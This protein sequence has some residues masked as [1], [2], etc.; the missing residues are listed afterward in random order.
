MSERL[1]TDPEN[2][3]TCRACGRDNPAAHKFCGTCGAD[4]R[5][6]E[7][8]P[9]PDRQDSTFPRA[10]QDSERKESFSQS[11]RPPQAFEHSITNPQEL[12]L[13]RSFRP[14]ESEDDD[15]ESEDGPN[16]RLYIGVFLVIVLIGLGF[17][18]WRGVQRQ[19][20]GQKAIAP[21]AAK[22]EPAQQPTPRTNDAA[23]QSQAKPSESQPAPPPVKAEA[24]PRKPEVKT[25]QGRETARKNPPEPSTAPASP[26]N[27]SE[28]LAMAE[29]YLSSGSGQRRDSAEAA[30]WLWKSIA[31]HNA[32]ATV[33]LADLYLR[34]DGVSKNCDQ[35][36][37]LLDSAA[38]K[39]SSLA[40]ERLR[41]L[42]AFGC[43]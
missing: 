28:E 14:A 26:G 4:L 1:G 43:Q 9:D 17:M 15:W 30:K 2:T 19:N 11:V 38:R 8:R 25:D 31:K 41:N 18:V 36:R 34:G 21:Q 32:E 12:S 10:S 7:S 40:G 3:V 24:P 5:V 29:R 13:F 6:E 39:G 42:Q 33:L 27:G 16:Y 23:K 35:A 37:V 22:Q 20:A